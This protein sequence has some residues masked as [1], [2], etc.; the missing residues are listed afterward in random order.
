MNQNFPKILAVI[1]CYNEAEA[2]GSLLREFATLKFPC[3]TLVIDDGSQDQTSAIA[4]ELSPVLRH[5]QNLG[6][7]A[8][9]KTGITY[10]LENG[11]DYCIQIDGDGQ[12]IPCH[13]PDFLKKENANL[14]IG[15]RYYRKRSY[16]GGLRRVGGLLIAAQVFLLFGRWLSDPLSGMR[17]M[18]RTAMQYFQQHLDPAS[19]DAALVPQALR[20][21]LS[22]AEIYMPM[23]PRQNGRSHLEGLNGIIF[24]LYLMYRILQ[25]RLKNPH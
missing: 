17:M 11:Y 21:K 4:R 1:P 9:L 18:D 19:L 22:I 6:I 8:A 16:K 25:L 12:H 10:A 5:E 7:A 3:D 24:M 15:S 13:I 14:I 23:R 20:A 2:I